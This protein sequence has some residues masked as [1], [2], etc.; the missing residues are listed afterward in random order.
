MK[1]KCITR[2]ATAEVETANV[3]SWQPPWRPP[4]SDAMTVDTMLCIW[5]HGRKTEVSPYEHR[6]HHFSAKFCS[7][8][9]SQVLTAVSCS[10]KV[11]TCY[12]NSVFGSGLF[13]RLHP[14]ILLFVVVV[15]DGWWC[16][17]AKSVN[18][19]IRIKNEATSFSVWNKSSVGILVIL[20]WQKVEFCL[21]FATK[22][23]LVRFTKNDS[24][25]L[26]AGLNFTLQ[27]WILIFAQSASIIAHYCAVLLNIC[28]F[29]CFSTCQILPNLSCYWWKCLRCLWTTPEY[30]LLPV[31]QWSRGNLFW[32]LVILDISKPTP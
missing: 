16:S 6:H 26:H 19:I 13:G 5:W 14:S 11:V 28:N 7:Q 21:I 8:W 30:Y 10:S 22:K 31:V 15:G 3:R 18:S 4:G 9:V 23:K 24:T 2:K 25:I 20:I 1:T 17:C 27:E 12:T 29:T 32:Y